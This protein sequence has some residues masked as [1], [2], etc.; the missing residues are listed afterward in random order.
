[1]AD[2]GYNSQIVRLGIPDR[3]VEHAEQNAQWRSSHYDAAAIV[4]EGKRCVTENSPIQWLD[5]SSHL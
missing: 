4:E 5:R 3:I 2:H 1:M